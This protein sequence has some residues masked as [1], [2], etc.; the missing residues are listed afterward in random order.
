[1]EDKRKEYLFPMCNEDKEHH[2]TF[3][4]TGGFESRSSKA[5]TVSVTAAIL[6][7]VLKRFNEDADILA[8]LEH[9]QN[10][11]RETKSEPSIESV[12]W[13]VWGVL[14][15]DDG[16]IVSRSPREI[17]KIMG[18]IAQVF[19]VFGLTASKKKT[20]TMCTPVPH[21]LLVLMLCDATVVA[22]GTFSYITL[23]LIQN[24][25]RHTAAS[26]RPRIHLKM[27]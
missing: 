10:Q 1:M 22:S 4:W 11:P 18:V 17:A 9:R 20:D 24:L 23:T 8:E 21:M 13:T 2:S 12:R 16:C 27:L 5:A 14:Y 7:V 25:K 3:C 19:Y 6:L 26:R 15:P